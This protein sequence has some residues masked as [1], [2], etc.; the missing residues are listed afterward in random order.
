MACC[1][2]RTRLLSS[3]TLPAGPAATL[4]PPPSPTSEP[5]RSPIVPISPALLFRARRTVWAAGLLPIA[6]IWL[7]PPLAMASPA[8]VR[9][10]SFTAVKERRRT[11]AGD[12]IA[13]GGTNQIAAIGKSPA[14]HTVRRARNSNAGEIGTMGERPGS[15]VGDGGGNSV[16]AGPAGRVLDE[17][18]LVLIEQHAIQAAVKRVR[19]VHV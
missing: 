1:S 17:S 6:A 18:S 12:A 5:G 11:K 9:R 3:N 8:L 7:V 13:N 10:R 4:F 14:A 19:G 15:D 2:I 16:A